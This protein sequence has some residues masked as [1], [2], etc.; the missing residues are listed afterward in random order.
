MPE[1]SIDFFLV[2]STPPDGEVIAAGTRRKRPPYSPDVTGQT[3]KR[4]II[5]MM[6][7]VGVGAAPDA[8]EYGD[9]GSDTLGHTSRAVG[10][11]HLPNLEKAGLGNLHGDL[12]GVDAVAEPSMAF[13]SNT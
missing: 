6:D 3:V 13:G 1:T 2:M 10:G 8:A 7:S 9:E 12:L 4:A 5:V 11:L